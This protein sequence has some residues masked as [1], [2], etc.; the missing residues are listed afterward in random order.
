MISNK[1]CW[2]RRSFKEVHLT[3]HEDAWTYL[4]PMPLQLETRAES[5]E[6]NGFDLLE[7]DGWRTSI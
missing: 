6:S 4:M 5:V 1:G 7:I 2:V 3:I